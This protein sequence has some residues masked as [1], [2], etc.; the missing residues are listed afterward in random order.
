MAKTTPGE[1]PI[2]PNW[3]ERDDVHNWRNYIS[4]RLR[5]IWHTFTDEQKVAIA[6]NAYDIAASEEWD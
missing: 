1:D 6:D 5:A 4:D 2:N 3:N